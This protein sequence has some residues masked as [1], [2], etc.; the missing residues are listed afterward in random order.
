MTRFE[1]VMRPSAV[2]ARIASRRVNGD[3]G[4]VAV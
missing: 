3:A 4:C 1:I 2:K